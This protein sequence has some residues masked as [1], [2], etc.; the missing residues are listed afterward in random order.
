MLFAI[1]AKVLLIY[2]RLSTL[3]YLLY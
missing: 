3:T 2:T 1:K